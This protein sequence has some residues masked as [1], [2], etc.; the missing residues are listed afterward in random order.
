MTHELTHVRCNEDAK[1]ERRALNDCDVKR[2]Y[3]EFNESGVENT[4]VQTSQE[5]AE[6]LRK[7]IA[8]CGGVICAGC[9]CRRTQGA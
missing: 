2:G 1:H 6:N 9:A 4:I 3:K 5:I 8:L 7:Q